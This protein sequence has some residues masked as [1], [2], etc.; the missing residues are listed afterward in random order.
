M[1]SCGSDISQEGV[2]I[3]AEA[4]RYEVA[5]VQ[6]EACQG[7]KA[8]GACGV[9]GESKAINVV[10]KEVSDIHV[11]DKV[12][13]SVRREI[14]FYATFF[15]YILPL[16]FFVGSVVLGVWLIGDEGLAALGGFGVVGVYYTALY[17][18]R[19]RVESRVRFEIKKK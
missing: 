16:L 2:V 3:K 14:A 1:S 9:N 8:Q 17:L 10:D 11:G 7:C 4:G 12:E 19:R 15:A 18:S 13:V 6:N 5:I